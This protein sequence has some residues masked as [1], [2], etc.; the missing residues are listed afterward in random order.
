MG[1]LNRIVNFAFAAVDAAVDG[2]DQLFALGVNR[3]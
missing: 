2:R 3:G 1:W